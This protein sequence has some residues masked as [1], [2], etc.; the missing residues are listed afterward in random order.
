MQLT[1]A[2]AP[3]FR[4]VNVT[5]PAAPQ[6][7]HELVPILLDDR[8]GLPARLALRWVMRSRRNAVSEKT[9]ADDLRAAALLYSFCEDRLDASLDELFADG[10]RLTA[11]DLDRLIEYLRTGQGGGRGTRALTTI[12]QSVPNIE[13]FLRWLAKPMDRGGTGFVPPSELTLY[14][15]Q[16]RLTFSDLRAF[17]SRGKRIEPFTAGEDAALCELIGPIK[18]EDGRYETPLRFPD[19]NPWHPKTRLRN[20]IGFLLARYSGLRRG[21]VGKLRTDDIR[22]VEGPCIAVV[23]R[24]QDALDTRTSSNRPK[25]KTVERELPISNVL[26]LALRQYSHTLLRDGGRRGARTPYLL[27]TEK[28]TPI[29]GSS[30]DAIWKAVNRKLS[31]GMSWHVLRHTWAEEV[32]DDLLEQYQGTA[33]ASE[34]VLGIIREMGGWAPTSNTPFIYI[35]NTLKKRG[36]AYLRKRNARFD[37]ELGNE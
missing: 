11:N 12:G 13:R 14:Y 21:E 32:A 1:G 20:W 25:V 17:R 30:L 36:N 35:K 18:R 4:I 15:E 5:L 24:S 31:R 37:K 8:T 33:D 27:V 29:S 23:R 22:N 19:H 16:L 10:H 2:T 7:E 6:Q 3:R 26:A 28:G 9:L 34:I